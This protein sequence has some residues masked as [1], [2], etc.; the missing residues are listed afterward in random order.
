MSV[1]GDGDSVTVPMTLMK[2]SIKQAA[3]VETSLRV[4]GSPYSDVKDVPNGE[5]HTDHVI[6]LITAVFRLAHVFK[7]A[8]Q[9]NTKLS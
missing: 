7:D 5:L 6:R 8:L 4:F 3:D 2:Y 1:D 9:S